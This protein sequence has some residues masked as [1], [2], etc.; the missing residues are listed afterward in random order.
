MNDIAKEL[1]DI[2]IELLKLTGN[3]PPNPAQITTYVVAHTPGSNQEEKTIVFESGVKQYVEV[4][5]SA[6]IFLDSGTL[7]VIGFTSGSTY[8]VISL[9]AFHL[10]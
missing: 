10:A 7:K 9:G 2:E 8:R 3:Q 1:A 5:G 4:Y 6:V